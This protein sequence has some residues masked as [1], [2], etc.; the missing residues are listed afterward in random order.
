M[1][2]FLKVAS[3]MRGVLIMSVTDQEYGASVD[4]QQLYPFR[5]KFRFIEVGPVEVE[6]LR[7]PTAE[8]SALA[9]TDDTG[10]RSSLARLAGDLALEPGRVEG[11]DL[12]DRNL[13]A[14]RCGSDDRF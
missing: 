12:R 8:P 9:Q 1:G 13:I 5:M 6:N 14:F 11:V 4:L 2:F 7:T 3:P 10:R